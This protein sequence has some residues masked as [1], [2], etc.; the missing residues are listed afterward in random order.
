MAVSQYSL[1][2]RLSMFVVITLLKNMVLVKISYFEVISSDLILC[3]SSVL[4]I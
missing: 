4:N 3:I 1:S 2:L